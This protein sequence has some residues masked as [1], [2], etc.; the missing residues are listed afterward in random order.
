MHTQ[1]ATF[2]SILSLTTLKPFHSGED[3]GRSGNAPRNPVGNS[4]VLA[5][6]NDNDDDVDNARVT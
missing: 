1:S 4:V 2:L 6:D 3:G 5:I